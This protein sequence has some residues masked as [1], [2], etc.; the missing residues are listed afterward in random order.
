MNWLEQFAGEI[1]FVEL[2]VKGFLIGV[3]VSAPLGPVG[4]MC[5]RRTLNKGRWHGFLTG[6][7]ASVSDLVYA[8]IT[9]YG[10]S[11]VF[12]FIN[13]A[14]TMFILQVAGSV[15]LFIFGVHTFRSNPHA[16]RNKPM[17]KMRTIPITKGK[18]AYNSVTGFALAIS[19]PLIILL[20]VALFARMSFVLPELPS[21]ERVAGY[22]AIWLG[23]LVWWFMITA[24]VN[25]LRNRFD[26]RGIWILNRVIGSIVMLFGVL[27]VVY[28][29]IGMKG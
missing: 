28:T 23:A 13:D 7:G 19:N 12:D 21:Y 18:L 27:G 5:I 11:F 6:L 25:K 16:Y 17:E 29:L 2:L 8:L 22:A 26:V 15:L 1:S 3:I 10:M 4:V 9:A 20:F 24:L 14:D